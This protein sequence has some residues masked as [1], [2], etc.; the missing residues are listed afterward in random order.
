MQ[1]TSTYVGVDH[2]TKT[3]RPIAAAVPMAKQVECGGQAGR[4][5]FEV[6][7]G[8]S[9]DPARP[10]PGHA[11]EDQFEVEVGGDAGETVPAMAA[12]VDDDKTVNMETSN[13]C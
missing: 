5:L 4:L 10:C 11:G 1:I 8:R 9:A 6:L 2:T 13:V 12:I 7:S 3:I